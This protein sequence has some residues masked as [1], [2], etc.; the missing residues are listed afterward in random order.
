MAIWSARSP[1]KKY[2][3]Y[4]VFTNHWLQVGMLSIE[5]AR[6][7]LGSPLTMY[8]MQ[9]RCAVLGFV[10]LLLLPSSASASLNATERQAKG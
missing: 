4:F 7:F 2:F 3:L 6:V 5:K 9:C 10:S 8:C 1:I